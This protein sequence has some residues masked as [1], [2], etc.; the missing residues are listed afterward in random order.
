MT[1]IDRQSVLYV[2]PWLQSF[3][4]EQEFRDPCFRRESSS[5]SISA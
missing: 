3:Y 5:E 2:H 1:Y 4:P